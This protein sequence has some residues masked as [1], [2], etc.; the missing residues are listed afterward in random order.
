L[1]KQLAFSISCLEKNVVIKTAYISLHFGRCMADSQYVIAQQLP[2]RNA[3]RTS[4]V[5]RTI[6]FPVTL[7]NLHTTHTRTRT[8][9]IGDGRFGRMARRNVLFPE[10][11]LGEKRWI[12][13][14]RQ[15]IDYSDITIFCWTEI[16]RIWFVCILWQRYRTD[17]I[18]TSRTTKRHNGL[19]SEGSRF[20][21]FDSEIS[22]GNSTEYF[23]ESRTFECRVV[24]DCPV[25]DEQ[26]LINIFHV[27]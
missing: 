3:V 16:F 22:D 12:R 6:N 20:S 25:A 24:C 9:M 26:I 8:Q 27:F 4:I 14:C 7:N 15:L 2:I 18:E 11:R 23:W 17:N 5:W 13:F 19:N 1:R 21:N 10:R